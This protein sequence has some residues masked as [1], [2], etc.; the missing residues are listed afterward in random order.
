MEII[1]KLIKDENSEEITLMQIEQGINAGIIKNIKCVCSVKE[2]YEYLQDSV[3]PK[4]FISNYQAQEDLTCK[5]ELIMG[6]IYS[7]EESFIDLKNLRVYGLMDLPTYMIQ[8]YDVSFERCLEA[9]RHNDKHLILEL[10][11]NVFER[12]FSFFIDFEENVIITDW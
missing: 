3:S 7:E 4:G 11:N 8:D 5:I 6:E 10:I 1:E 9:Y 2:L 12:D